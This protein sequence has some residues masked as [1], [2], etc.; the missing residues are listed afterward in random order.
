MSC[1]RY[2]ER[3]IV[4][5]VVGDNEGEGVGASLSN[6]GFVGNDVTSIC[7]VGDDFS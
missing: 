6:F 3:L 7:C 1:S 5:V 2:V 4:G